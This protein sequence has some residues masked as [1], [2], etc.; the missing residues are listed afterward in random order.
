MEPVD[1]DGLELARHRPPGAFQQIKIAEIAETHRLRH[2]NHVGRGEIAAGGFAVGHH[3]HRQS[4]AAPVKGKPA[5]IVELAAV[6]PGR[7]E[8]RRN[9]A[10]DELFLPLRHTVHMLDPA[11]AFGQIAH[12]LAVAVGGDAKTAEA[13]LLHKPDQQ[14]IDHGAADAEHQHLRNFFLDRQLP[15]QCIETA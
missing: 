14:R 5:E 8:R 7:Q 11:R 9:L 1:A 15:E 12:R 10:V 2:R 13:V 6:D 3:M 4:E